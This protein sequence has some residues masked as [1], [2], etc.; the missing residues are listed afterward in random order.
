MEASFRAMEI[1]RRTN[2]GTEFQSRATQTLRKCPG[3]VLSFIVWIFSDRRMMF[4]LLHTFIVSF[5]MF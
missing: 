2:E 1:G 5:I 3:F 4:L